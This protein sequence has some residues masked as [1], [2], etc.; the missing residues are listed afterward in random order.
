MQLPRSQALLRT[1]RDPVHGWKSRTKIR[2]Q[3]RR[4]KRARGPQ[5]H[6]HGRP[7]TLRK[8]LEKLFPEIKAVRGG[9]VPGTEECR[10]F[11]TSVPQSLWK[12]RRQETGQPCPMLQELF[13]LDIPDHRAAKKAG[14]R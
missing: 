5:P 1:D 3:Q 7:F 14:T 12:P 9:K 13:L 4:Q 6:D 2:A 10:H 8:A 11:R